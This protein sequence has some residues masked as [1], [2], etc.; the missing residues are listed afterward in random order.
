MLWGFEIHC[1]ASP[2]PIA[3]ISRSETTTCIAGVLHLVCE[4]NL[5]ENCPCRRYAFKMS[6]EK[7][8]HL[9][10]ENRT[11]SGMLNILLVTRTKVKINNLKNNSFLI[12]HFSKG[13]LVANFRLLKKKKRYSHTHTLLLYCHITEFAVY[14]GFS[15]RVRMGG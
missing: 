2:L 9:R 5:A 13:T 14:Q 7:T 15:S 12:T 10:Y 4:T 1:G 8:G 6:H 11:T 3:C